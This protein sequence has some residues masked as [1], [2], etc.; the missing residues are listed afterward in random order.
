MEEMKQS[1]PYRKKVEDFQRE[2]SGHTFP[3][4]PSDL[5][6]CLYRVFEKVLIAQEEV[7]LAIKLRSWEM[8]KLL[9]GDF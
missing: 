2:W 9:V 7:I 4:F 1:F 3:P 8:D 6:K 5:S